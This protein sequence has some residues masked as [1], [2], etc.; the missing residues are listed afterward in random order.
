M[1]DQQQKM[2]RTMTGWVK[3]AG[4]DKTVA[5]TVERRVAH[6]L[7]G[8]FI[9]RSTRVLAHDEDNSCRTGDLVTVEECRPYSKRKSW[10]VQA[11]LE[12]ASG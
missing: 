5:V 1:S 2:P 7:Y 12:R 10:K 4:A 9:R 6:P 3:S 11:V 8:K